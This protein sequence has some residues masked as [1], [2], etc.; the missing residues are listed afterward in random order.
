MKLG[1]IWG[2]TSE[3]FCYLAVSLP[4]DFPHMITPEA[5]LAK[6]ALETG[7]HISLCYRQ[8]IDWWRLGEIEAWFRD[9]V[10][11]HFKHVYVTCGGTLDLV[12]DDLVRWLSPVV[13]QGTGKASVHVSM[14]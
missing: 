8:K 13:I 12:C 9:K 5:V 3:G 4:D 6:R 7:F 10:Q 11:H 1:L 14:D 2:E